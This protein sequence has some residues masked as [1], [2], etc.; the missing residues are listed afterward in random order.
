ML[1]LALIFAAAAAIGG[2]AMFANEREKFG[3]ALPD[4]VAVRARQGRS[5][6]WRLIVSTMDGRR[7]NTGLN[8]RYPTA[9]DALRLARR[10]HV[11][12]SERIE[13]RRPRGDAKRPPP[14]RARE[15]GL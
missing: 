8:P 11:V 7:V 14:D 3:A 1:E 10:V 15:A 9:E 6:E 5:G 12:A 4:P 2:W 13:P